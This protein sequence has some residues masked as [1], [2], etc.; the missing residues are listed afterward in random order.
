MTVCW[1]TNFHNYSPNLRLRK[2]NSVTKFFMTKL[3]KDKLNSDFI[4]LELC[5]CNENNK[6][7]DI[8]M[9]ETFNAFVRFSTLSKNVIKI[10]FLAMWLLSKKM[11]ICLQLVYQATCLLSNKLKVISCKSQFLYLLLVFAAY[12]KIK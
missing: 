10:D 5:H 4:Q 8:C 12:F 11:L 9:K 3:Q 1:A 7:R 2:A 6:R